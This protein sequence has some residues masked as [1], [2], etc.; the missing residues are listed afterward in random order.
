MSIL[1]S[2][3]KF[4]NNSNIKSK[5]HHGTDFGSVMDF[6]DIRLRR[7]GQKTVIFLNTTISG[8][9]WIVINISFVQFILN[10]N[11]FHYLTPNNYFSIN[12]KTMWIESEIVLTYGEICVAGVI[13]N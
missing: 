4:I 3:R 10:I 12:P 13:E 6:S 1:K 9:I 8:V 2:L 5:N 11:I 7:N